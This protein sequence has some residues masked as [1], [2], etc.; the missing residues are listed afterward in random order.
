MVL[1]KY[2]EKQKEYYERFRE[3]QKLL[4]RTP[5]YTPE[6]YK[7]NKKSMD[8]AHKRYIQKCQDKIKAYQKRYFQENKERLKLLQTPLTEEQRL[9]KNRKMKEYFSNPEV[10]RKQHER[11]LE[12]KN[13]PEYK[14]VKKRF[15]EKAKEKRL[16]LK[17][18]RQQK[19]LEMKEQIKQEKVLTLT[20]QQ[21]EK[22]SISLQQLIDWFNRNTENLTD[23]K[24]NEIK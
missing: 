19:K 7:K 6:V 9:E 16:I 24:I 21:L 14:A 17:Q 12:R 2:K 4:G 15:Q 10:K 22:H 13:T 1:N 8:A 23:E 11:Y 5:K 20:T 18:E 3:K